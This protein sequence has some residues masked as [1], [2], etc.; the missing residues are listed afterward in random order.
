[1]KTVVVTGSTRG[2]GQGMAQRFLERGCNVVISG[3]QQASVDAVVAGFAQR[4]PAERVF[5]LVCDVG[6]FAQV[7]ALWDASVA[8]FGGVDIWVNNAAITNE[9]VPLWEQTPDDIERVVKANMLG[10]MYGSKVAISGMLAQGR[11]HVYNMEGIGSEGRIAAG[12]T[13]YGST[14][15]ALRY[16]TKALAQDLKGKPVG[17]STISPGMVVTDML[18]ESV[19]PDRRHRAK[20]VFNILADKVETVSPW[21]SDQM[22][23]NEKSGAAIAWMTTPKI[24][25]RFLQAPFHKRDLFGEWGAS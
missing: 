21:L 23:A 15:Y 7:Q 10:V 17:V 16:L 13:T 8:R 3:R 20:R 22:L 1:M 4:F 11:G 24:F 19:S 12:T 25:M 18:M 5:G 14:K 6:E 9:P 2:I